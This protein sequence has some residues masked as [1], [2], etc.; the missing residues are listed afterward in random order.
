MKALSIIGMVFSLILALL[1]FAVIEIRCYDEW[2]S[3]S[4]GQEIGLVIFV[5]AAFYLA[6]SIV[7]CVYAFRKKKG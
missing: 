6:F 3:S 5:L 4:P 1:S 2:G 7:A